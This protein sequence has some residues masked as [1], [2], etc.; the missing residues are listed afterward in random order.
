MVSCQQ[1]GDTIAEVKSRESARS[2]WLPRARYTQGNIPASAY[3]NFFGVFVTD[4]Q[5]DSGTYES[6]VIRETSNPTKDQNQ[7]C[8]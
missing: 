6:F 2:P 1:L 4:S 8:S 7:F 5:W 3:L